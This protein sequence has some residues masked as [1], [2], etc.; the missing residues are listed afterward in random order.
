MII[1]TSPGRYSAHESIGLEVQ[2]PF[3]ELPIRRI[4][5]PNSGLYAGSSMSVR[6][7]GCDLRS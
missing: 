7:T 1:D 3:A 4:I 5:Q 2:R 6:V